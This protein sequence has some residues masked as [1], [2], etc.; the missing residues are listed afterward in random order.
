MGAMGRPAGGAVPPPA[1]AAAV[2]TPAAVAAPAAVVTQP[3]AAAP[4]PA[5]AA[6]QE[7][8]VPTGTGRFCRAVYNYPGNA[9]NNIYAFAKH[10]QF[11]I[12]MDDGDWWL[13]KPVANAAIEPGFV[14]RNYV[15]VCPAPA[16]AVPPPA[17]VPVP[18]PAPPREPTPPPREPTPPPAP[19]APVELRVRGK[20]LFEGQGDDFLPFSAGDEL[21]V[22][23]DT[24]GQDWWVARH[25]ITGKSGY[26]P[27]NFVEI[28]Q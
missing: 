6:E 5:P 19:V 23:G 16:N 14:P 4:A 1:P 13:V 11:E 20:Y 2:A 7:P 3:A 24:A 18:A 9:D 28:I 27:S 26:I 17:P 22:T 8:D 12:Y 10:D 15:E 25:C 21:I